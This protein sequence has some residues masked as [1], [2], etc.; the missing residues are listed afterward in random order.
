[1]SSPALDARAAGMGEQGVATPIEERITDKVIAVANQAITNPE[2]VDID[3]VKRVV[4]DEITNNAQANQTQADQVLDEI[5]D[6][7][8][9]KGKPGW[10]GL[11]MGVKIGIIGGGAVVLGLIGY[12]IYKSRGKGKS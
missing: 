6:P 11:S 7:N 2:N 3:A 4:T 1:M 12:A 8:N 10:R 5:L 9:S